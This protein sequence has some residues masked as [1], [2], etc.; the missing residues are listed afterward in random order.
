[1]HYFNSLM[2]GREVFKIAGDQGVGLGRYSTGQ[3]RVVF[4]VLTEVYLDGRLNKNTGCRQFDNIIVN[5]GI[6]IFKALGIRG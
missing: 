3:N 4:R 2:T 5:V 1:M 6:W